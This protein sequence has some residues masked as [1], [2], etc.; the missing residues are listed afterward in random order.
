MREMLTGR[1]FRGQTIRTRADVQRTERIHEP[2]VA[3]QIAS[4][5]VW[6]TCWVL[7]MT[8]WAAFYIPPVG[9]ALTAAVL[10]FLTGGG[11]GFLVGLVFVAVGSWL[12]SRR[13]PASWHRWATSR[14]QRFWRRIR[15]RWTW[16]DVLAATDVK[17]TD[18]SHRV[19]VPRL[20]WVR[21]GEHIDELSVQLCAGVT[22]GVIARQADTLACEWC[23]LEVRVLP[24]PNRA[25]WVLLRVVYRDVL[26]DDHTEDAAEIDFNSI[27][28][29]RREDGRPWLLRLM[30]T[31]VLIAGLTGAGKSGLVARIVKALAPAIH[32]GRVRL[33]GCD[34]KS[35][36]EYR[37]FSGLFHMLAYGSDENLVA[38]LEAAASLMRERAD[39]L[40]GKVRKLSIPTSAFPLWV[41]LVDE[42][43]ALTSYIADKQLKDRAYAALMRMLTQGRAP[44][45]VV[46][47]CVQDPRKDT[48]PIR[49]RFG[50]RVGLR[51]D[52]D[53]EVKMVLGDTAYER[54]A[55]CDCIPESAPGMGYVVDEEGGNRTPVKVRADWVSDSELVFL[56]SEY[57]SPTQEDVPALADKKRNS[58]G[59][60]AS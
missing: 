20:L 50:Y 37:M 8:A 57:P 51:L 58:G 35:G 38:A 9:A 14:A 4:A 12:W 13:W 24:H 21:L 52:S 49:D 36:M 31:H 18:A 55:H 60:Q 39:A 27:E 16:D 34:P 43:A 29:G 5:L 44:G 22:P 46:I 47:G 26:A 11:W 56:A 15:Y 19:V 32:D 23:A 1:L 40:G 54:G 45:V 28:V 7:L 41:I 3:E 10:G 25:G 6:W 17:A 48:L 30:G 2:S 59:R 53:D 42:I 33:I